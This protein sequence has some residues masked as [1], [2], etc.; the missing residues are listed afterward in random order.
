MACSACAL[1]TSWPAHT[2]IPHASVRTSHCVLLMRTGATTTATTQTPGT[3]T[4][5]CAGWLS[6]H[7]RKVS[8]ALTPHQL[9]IPTGDGTKGPHQDTTATSHNLA[10][11]RCVRHVRVNSSSSTVNSRGMVHSSH[12]VNSWQL[13][14]P[15]QHAVLWH[16]LVQPCSMAA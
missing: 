15:G 10:A 11:D 12:M 8:Q 16:A 3:T 2:P 9:C 4:W 13:Q 6:A 1:A 5:S 7:C 14:V